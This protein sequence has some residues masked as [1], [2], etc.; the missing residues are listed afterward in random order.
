M[1]QFLN[2]PKVS[3]VLCTYN[4]AN[5]IKQA[6]NSV[7]RQSF[8]EFEVLIMDDCSVDNTKEKI[9]PYLNDPRVIYI[10]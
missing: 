2:K 8:K 5:F 1:E 4:R 9:A 3:V 7:L 6:L 10:Q